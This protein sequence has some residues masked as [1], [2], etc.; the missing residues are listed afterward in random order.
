M[1]KKVVQRGDFDV[2][3]KHIDRL[4]LSSDRRTPISAFLKRL[5]SRLNDRFFHGVRKI[6]EKASF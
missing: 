1:Q 5:F 4:L 3:I 6:I 2:Q